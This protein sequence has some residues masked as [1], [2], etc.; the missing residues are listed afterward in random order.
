MKTEVI[1]A[2]GLAIVSGIGCAFVIITGIR[3]AKKNRKNGP[4]KDRN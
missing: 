4:F 3:D 1:L 2:I